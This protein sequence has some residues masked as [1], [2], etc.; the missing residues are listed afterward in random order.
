MPRL[1]RM[2]YPPVGSLW[3]IKIGPDIPK[4]TVAII[5]SG[6]GIVAVKQIDGKYIVAIDIQ[7]WYRRYQPCAKSE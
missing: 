6:H 3:E 5:S 1:A 2:K 7:M 4:C